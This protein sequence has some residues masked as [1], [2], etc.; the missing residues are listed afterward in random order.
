MHPAQLQ[1]THDKIQRLITCERRLDVET[2]LR[3]GVFL[4]SALRLIEIVHWESWWYSRNN[5]RLWCFREAAVVAVQV[6]VGSTDRA[7]LH[8]LA[9]RTDGFS[10][11][12]F[13]SPV[14]K[15]CGEEF[16]NRAKLHTHSCQRMRELAAPPAL[17]SGKRLADKWPDEWRTSP[18]SWWSDWQST[19][20]RAPGQ[21]WD[22]QEPSR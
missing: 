18:S 7:F 3:R 15:A 16:V 2:E 10:V 17:A 11:V 9:A 12:F 21:W 22:R 8:G 20:C 13:P 6:R 1:W 5:R 4:P 19:P 14:C